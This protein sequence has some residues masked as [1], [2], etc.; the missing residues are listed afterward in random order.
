VARRW[1][2]RFTAEGKSI[3]TEQPLPQRLPGP[4]GDR[5]G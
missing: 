3:W 2:T 4:E 1:G 5:A